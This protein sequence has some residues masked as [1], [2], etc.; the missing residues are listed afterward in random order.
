MKKALIVYHYIAHYRLPI[1]DE[2]SKTEEYRFDFAAGVETDQNIKIVSDDKLNFI[3]LR[4]KWFF[5]KRV[6]W[7]TGLFKLIRNKEYSEII[8]LGNPYFISTWIA[9]FYIRFTKMKSYIWTHG[10]TDK[11]SGLKLTIFK[12]FWSLVD[13]IL[14]YGNYAK[15]NM[16]ALGVDSSN[17]HVIYNSLDY[18]EQLKIRKTLKKTS[19]YI[20]YFKNNKPVIIFTG[21]LTEVK[22]LDQLLKAQK[23]LNNFNIV[24]VGDGNEKSKLIKLAK[25]LEV[26]SSCWFYGECYDE[27]KIGE[28]FYNA[29]VCVAPGNVGLTAMHSMVFGTPVISHSNFMLQMPEFEAIIPGKT[30]DFFEM[31]DIGNLAKVLNNWIKFNSDKLNKVENDC[32]DIIAS[33]YNPKNQ[34]KLIV[35][36]L[37]NV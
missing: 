24:F 31:D 26:F 3:R 17:L 28:L 32:F 7:Q 20:D 5:G 33:K 15:T 12:V 19:V 25:E 2:L 13:G 35:N 18:E 11:L 37:N 1:F 22:K 6:L 23:V 36:L 16:I 30:G 4:N 14:L 21:R 9:L 27:A 29:K 10:Y 34:I 8:F